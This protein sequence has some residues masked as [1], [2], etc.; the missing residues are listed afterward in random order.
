MELREAILEGTIAVFNRKGLKLTMDDIARQLGISKKT[1]YRVFDNK[2]SLFSAM[3]DYIFDIIE[4]SE[5]QVVEDESLDTLKKVHKIVSDLPE[6][7]KGID[8]QRLG[9]L[10]EK[11]PGTYAKVG[12]RLATEWDMMISL[13]EQGM[14]EGVIR[15]VEIPLV[16]LMLGATL[17]RFFQSDI[18]LRH[19]I[20]Y[21][22]AKRQIADILVNGIAVHGAK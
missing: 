3:V 17:E 8:F 15:Q 2:E 14:V 4:E 5:R 1:I 21:M 16:Q 9:T 10:R 19:N 11:Y 12:E 18:L 7:L 22:D 13:L 6:S 20:T